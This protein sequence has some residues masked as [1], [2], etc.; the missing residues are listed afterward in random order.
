MYVYHLDEI[1]NVTIKTVSRP[2]ALFKMTRDL[3]LISCMLSIYNAVDEDGNEIRQGHYK[4]NYIK[5][6]EC[7]ESGHLRAVFSFSRSK[8]VPLSAL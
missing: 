7:T 1:L 2:I 5:T 4:E 3:A 6:Q 8:R